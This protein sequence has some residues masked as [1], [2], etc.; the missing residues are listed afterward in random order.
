MRVDEEMNDK[1]LTFQ[2]STNSRSN[3]MVSIKRD[4]EGGDNVVERLYKDAGDRI[5]KA[6]MTARIR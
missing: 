5:E 1:N 3:K 4:E 6:M 2:P